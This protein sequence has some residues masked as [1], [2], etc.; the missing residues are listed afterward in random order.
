MP[1]RAVAEFDEAAESADLLQLLTGG[2]GPV[3]SVRFGGG[4]D[5]AITPVHCGIRKIRLATDSAR[6]LAGPSLRLWHWLR[7]PRVGGACEKC[8]EESCREA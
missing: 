5:A 3:P 2:C 8:V 1:S 6:L 7:R 4:A